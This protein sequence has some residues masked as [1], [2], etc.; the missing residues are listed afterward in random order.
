V[1]LKLEILLYQ[2]ILISFHH[3]LYKESDLDSNK[4]KGGSVV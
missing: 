4:K 1:I 2:Y 3:I